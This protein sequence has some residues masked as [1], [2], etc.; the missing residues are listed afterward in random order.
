VGDKVVG[1]RLWVFEA[2]W[3]WLS[4]GEEYGMDEA[5]SLWLMG[6]GVGSGR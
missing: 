1:D 6:M 2:D 3:G 5:L 4:F